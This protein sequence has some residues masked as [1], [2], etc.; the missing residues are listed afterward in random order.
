LQRSWTVSLVINDAANVQGLNSHRLEF[1]AENMYD[2]TTH[3]VAVTA[4][5]STTDGQ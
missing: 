1:V 3:A 2:I 5:V 4:E